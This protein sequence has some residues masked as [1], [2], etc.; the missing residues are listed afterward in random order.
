[1]LPATITLLG[2]SFK[3]RDMLQETTIKFF[4]VRGDKISG[5]QE[6]AGVIDPKAVVRATPN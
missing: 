6:Y 1:M 4:D 3:L 5:F 2:L